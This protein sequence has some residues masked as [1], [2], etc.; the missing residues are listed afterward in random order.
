[1]SLW[2]KKLR[3]LFI[4]DDYIMISFNFTNK[5]NLISFITTLKLCKWHN[6]LF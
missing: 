2:L 1:M 4:D 5:N 3:I 6:A